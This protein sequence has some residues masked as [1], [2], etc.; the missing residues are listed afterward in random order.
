MEILTQ[1]G[2]LSFRTAL[3]LVLGLV[4]TGGGAVYGQA[5][6]EYELKAAFLFNFTK[7]IEWPPASL[8]NGAF[9]IGV[10]GDDP[11]GSAID[12]VIRGKNVNGHQI[13]IRRLK[14][15]AEARDCHMVF[16]SSTDSKKIKELLDAT[17]LSPVL[18]VGES[19]EFLNQGGTIRF[20]MDGNRVVIVINNAAAA[21]KGLKVSAKLLSLAKIYEKGKEK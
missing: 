3:W 11:F 7:F 8:S 5:V 21:A 19:R 1:N 9:I 15:P 14:E 2:T 13:Q 20:S 10:F 12:D 18:I 17:N 16:V 6:E 4:M